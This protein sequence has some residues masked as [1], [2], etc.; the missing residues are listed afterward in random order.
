MFPFEQILFSADL[1]Y[2]IIYTYYL[3]IFT[4]YL[5]Y[6]FV[7]VLVLVLG[8]AACGLQ[9][10]VCGLLP[11][12]GGGP[13]YPVPFPDGPRMAWAQYIRTWPEGARGAFGF[14]S[15]PPVWISFSSFLF[16]FGTL[17]SDE[18]SLKLMCF[19]GARPLRAKFS[20]PS[21]IL[22]CWTLF[23]IIF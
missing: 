16:S 7:L 17:S 5:F 9:F 13:A 2:Y 23:V 22:I 14:V 20:F 15:L 1:K 10:A 18:L 8:V 12:F 6:V 21:K 3:C 19:L 11:V 4:N